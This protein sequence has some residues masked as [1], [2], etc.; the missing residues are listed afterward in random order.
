MEKKR[1]KLVVAYD[2]TDYHGWQVQDN[3]ITVAGELNRCLTDLLQEK[4]EVMGAS[5]P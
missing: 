5:H 3:G 2:G 1:V 4:I